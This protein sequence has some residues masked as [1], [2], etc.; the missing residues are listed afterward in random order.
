MDYSVMGVRRL[1]GAML[2]A[3]AMLCSGRL[4]AQTPADPPTS[5]APQA[6]AAQE[7]QPIFRGGIDLVTIRAVVRD[8]KGRP[9]TG[10]TAREFLLVDNGVV[11]RP[12]AVE[13]DNGPI[14]VALMFDISGSMDIDERFARARETGYYL[15]SGLRSGEDEAAI[16]A[17]DSS[18]HM[19]QPFTTDLDRLKGTVTNFSPWG[20]TSIHD[21]IASASRSMDSRATKRRA[22]VVL[23]DGF[24]TASKLDAAEVSRIASSIDLPVYVLAVVPSIDDPRNQE[25]GNR[26][27]NGDLA[28]L[29]RWTG[30][31]L[32]IATST[33][34]A[35][36]VAR[37]L[38]GELREQYL[39]ALEPGEKPGWHSVEVRVTRKNCTVQARG[40][41]VA[42]PRRPVS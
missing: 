3:A 10:L 2:L 15:L 8:G 29:A 23:T 34:E 22:L 5:T 13:H 21:A 7:G 28:D 42:G 18:L 11:R 35:S 24:D 32:F 20:M 16:F 26:A 27:L 1:P 19:V 4:A 9:V 17:F 37:E 14:G 6:P 41:Y 38:V 36:N 39:I 31:Q 25:G 33:P 12:N 40:G 30:G